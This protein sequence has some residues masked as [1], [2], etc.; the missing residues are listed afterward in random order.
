MLSLSEAEEG[1]AE[2]LL[3]RCSSFSLSSG[4]N[5]TPFSL[6]SLTSSERTSAMFSKSTEWGKGYHSNHIGS[7]WFSTNFHP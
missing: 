5:T 7:Q 2:L 4:S 3:K 6:V 1:Y